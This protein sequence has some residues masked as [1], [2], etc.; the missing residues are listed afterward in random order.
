MIYSLDFYDD[1]FFHLFHF[2]FAS[3]PSSVSYTTNDLVFDWEESDPLVVEEH[4]ELPQHDLISKDIDYCTTDYS[5]GL[6]S[7]F[8]CYLLYFI[9]I[10]FFV[11]ICTNPKIGTFACVQVI[12][13]IKR[14]LGK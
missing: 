7:F 1:N 14:R 4:I 8:F 6:F 10:L 9:F 2:T 13:T 5:S 12:F 3:S 11:C